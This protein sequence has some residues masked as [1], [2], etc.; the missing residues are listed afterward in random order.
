MRIS[1]HFHKDKP[2]GVRVPRLSDADSPLDV[3]ARD[4]D[5]IPRAGY[6]RKDTTTPFD[7]VVLNR[8]TVQLALDVVRRV[9]RL[10]T[11]AIRATQ[12]LRK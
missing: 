8:M 10:K 3:P 7:M 4:H 11:L 9:P 1:T 6:V 2:V 5:N 12:R